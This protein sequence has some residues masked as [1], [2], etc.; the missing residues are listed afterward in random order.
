MV[1]LFP[2]SKFFFISRR[3]PG[4]SL[5]LASGKRYSSVE[6][7]Y[8]TEPRGGQKSSN[9]LST[10][11]V[12]AWR[13]CMVTLKRRE[14]YTNEKSRLEFSDLSNSD[15]DDLKTF[16]FVNKTQSSSSRECGRK[17]QNKKQ[18]GQHTPSSTQGG[19][20]AGVWKADGWKLTINNDKATHS[21]SINVYLIF[22]YTSLV[23]DTLKY[24]IHSFKLI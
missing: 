12:H 14:V 23:L 20:W 4:K 21:H 1:V 7:K 22:P 3:W 2:F 11:C 13:I 24:S 17:H 15:L 18:W 10:H 6:Q 9:N 16:L 19:W 8:H 5:A